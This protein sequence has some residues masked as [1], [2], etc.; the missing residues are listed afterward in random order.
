[1]VIKRGS[2]FHIC[3]RRS[4]ATV[5]ELGFKKQKKTSAEIITLQ[6]TRHLNK[7]PMRHGDQKPTI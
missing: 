1:M 2:G 7:I 3:H 5:T 4:V 6:H